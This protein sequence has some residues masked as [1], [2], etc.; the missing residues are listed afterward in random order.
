MPPSANQDSGSTAIRTSQ[1][2]AEDH[3]LRGAQLAQ[4]GDYVQAVEQLRRALEI[5]PDLHTTRLQL[6]LLYLTMSRPDDALA[7]WTPLHRLHGDALCFFAEGLSALIRDDFVTCIARLEA[8]IKLNTR[9]LPLNED[10]G[11]VIRRA[12]DLLPSAAT[13]TPQVRT[14]FSLYDQTK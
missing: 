9:N 10:M 3:Y 5:D 12:R 7:V 11:L 13:D 8:G 4:S 1:S 2:A 6:G 14:D